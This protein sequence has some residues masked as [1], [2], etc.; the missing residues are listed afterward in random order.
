VVRY[1]AEWNM[2]DLQ[3]RAFWPKCM[4]VTVTCDCE[5]E[6][7]ALV[8][9]IGLTLPA[10]HRPIPRSKLAIQLILVES[11]QTR[12]LAHS[13]CSATPLNLYI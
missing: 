4:M 11:L 7:A 9:Q 13:S 2:M 3:G 5:E 12:P 8:R 10:L 6:R 1:L